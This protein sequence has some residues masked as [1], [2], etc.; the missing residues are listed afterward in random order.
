MEAS[1]LCLG[2]SGSG[3]ISYNENL[4]KLILHGIYIL[5]TGLCG[6]R[7]EASFFLDIKYFNKLYLKYTGFF[8]SVLLN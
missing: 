2:D 7:D 1:R 3:L 5:T 4:G 6:G 8:Y